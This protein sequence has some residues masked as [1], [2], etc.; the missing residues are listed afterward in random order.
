MRFEKVRLT[1]ASGIEVASAIQYFVDNELEDFYFILEIEDDLGNTEEIRIRPM[2]GQ[3]FIL[4]PGGTQVIKCMAKDGRRI[5]VLIPKP[6]F[7]EMSAGVIIGPPP[8][9]QN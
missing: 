4:S 9:E 7:R 5:D 3:D 2:F 6:E 8:D 1:K